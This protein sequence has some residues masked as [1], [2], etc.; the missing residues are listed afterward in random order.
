MKRNH[1]EWPRM[2]R[3]QRLHLGLVHGWPRQPVDCLCDFQAGRFRKRHALGCQRR[4]CF[5]K[6]YKREPSTRDRRLRQEEAAAWRE[7]HQ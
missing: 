7:H 4:N 5:C 2:R 3:K 1:E 6:A